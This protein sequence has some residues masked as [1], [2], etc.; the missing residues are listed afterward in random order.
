MRRRALEFG[1]E[2]RMSSLTVLTSPVFLS[3]PVF[4][5]LKRSSWLKSRN[6]SLKQTRPLFL[7]PILDVVDPSLLGTGFDSYSILGEAYV[8]Y[9]MKSLGTNSNL[10]LGYQRYDV[11][12]MGSDD[13]RMIPNTFE[14]YK[15]TNKDINNV[16]N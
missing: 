1:L 8:N 12:M 7:R 4:S 9:D 3:L 14:A 16:T 13:A 11:P 10:K 15:F 6:S 5:T 2:A